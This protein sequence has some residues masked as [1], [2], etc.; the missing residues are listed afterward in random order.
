MGY[1][2]KKINRRFIRIELVK[3]VL[4]LLIGCLL[5]SVALHVISKHYG[6]PF[7]PLNFSVSVQTT[8]LSG[9]QPEKHEREPLCDFSGIRSDVCEM[10]GDIRIHGNSSS[11]LFITPLKRSTSEVY[12]SWQIK[13]HARKL[14]KHALSHVTE[15]SVR[16]MTAEEGIP[17]C[18]AKYTIPAIIFSTGGYMG[19]MFHDFT[20]VLIPL[21]ITSRQFYGEIQF[22]VSDMQTWWIEKYQ[23]LLEQLS[24]YEIIN[25]NKE[26][27]VLCYPHVIVGL[28]FH[29]EMSIDPSKSANRYSMIDFARLIRSSFALERESAIKLANNDDTKPRLLIIS[30]KWTRSFTNIDEIV[31]MAGGLGY[32]VIVAEAELGSN[33]ANFAQI[34]NSCDVLMGVHGAGLTNLV[35]LPEN[36]T[37]IQVVPVGGLE[38]IALEDF[39]LPALDMQLRYLQYSINEEESSLIEQY[40]RDHPVFKDPASIR[41]QGW[42][43][44][45]STYLIK[46]NV[47][48]DVGRFKGVLLQALKFLY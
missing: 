15:M 10:K 41:K 23:P 3:I 28:K 24:R 35:F 12:E 20:D 42:L 47:C 8:A 29:K 2:K 39:G 7:L 6:S 31:Q 27:R 40:P 38:R 19:N 14:D 30:R 37:L 48:L 5:A 25:L 9:K 45:R 34:V 11:I 36:A 16:S 33:L 46:Q 17:E 21:F 32:E 22:L 18:T 1:E 13:P 4:V 26:T 43:A 44:L